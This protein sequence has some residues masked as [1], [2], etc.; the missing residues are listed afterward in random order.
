MANCQ[1]SI[2]PN[3]QQSKED[4]PIWILFKCSSRATPEQCE[5]HIERHVAENKGW[6]IIR[7]QC[8]GAYPK[9]LALLAIKELLFDL[10]HIQPTAEHLH[11]IG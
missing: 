5:A 1:L 9:V 8:L 11:S 7:G 6:A 2:L 10:L 4:L 3:G